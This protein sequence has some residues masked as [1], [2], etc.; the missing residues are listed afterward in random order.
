MKTITPAI[1]A[2]CIC[3]ATSSQTATAGNADRALGACRLLDRTGLPSEPC[4]VSGWNQ[5][6]SVSL[7]MESAEAR[8]SCAPIVAMLESKGYRLSSDWSLHITSPYSGSK[9][10]ARCKF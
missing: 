10:I 1:I 4:E 5:S 3:I 6:I 8:K 2:A 9:T 7:D